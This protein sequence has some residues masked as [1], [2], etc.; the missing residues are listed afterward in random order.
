MIVCPIIG[1][2]AGTVARKDAN[3]KAVI[4]NKGVTIACFS[5]LFFSYHQVF[6]RYA[7]EQAM[8]PALWA[9]GFSSW[10]VNQSPFS[11]PPFLSL[12]KKAT[13][14]ATSSQGGQEGAVGKGKEVKWFPSSISEATLLEETEGVVFLSPSPPHCSLLIHIVLS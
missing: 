8:V 7:G 10:I 9:A 1:N 13:P 3:T 11:S 6:L 14:V 12:E 4:L 2:T 5:Q